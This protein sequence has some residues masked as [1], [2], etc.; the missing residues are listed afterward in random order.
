MARY[1]G[2]GGWMA[3]LGCTLSWVYV[4]N[5]G[6][7]DQ[8][9]S[10][11]GKTSQ[12]ICWPRAWGSQPHL[13]R[14]WLLNKN[15]ANRDIFVR[16]AVFFLRKMFYTRKISVQSAG[17]DHRI[18]IP[19]RGCWTPSPRQPLALPDHRDIAPQQ[20][21]QCMRPVAIQSYNILHISSTL[22]AIFLIKPA[23]QANLSIVYVTF[24]HNFSALYI[25]GYHS[26]RHCVIHYVEHVLLINCQE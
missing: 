14:N 17:P 1:Q 21:E 23:M 25:I 4:G 13:A 24:F 16:L 6:T 8:K 2:T 26:L 12:E 11:P 18:I 15:T 19:G 9:N 20:K 3:W 5:R 10:E 7:T 22:L